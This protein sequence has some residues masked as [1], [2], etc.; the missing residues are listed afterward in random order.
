MARVLSVGITTLDIINQVAAYPSED[1][2]VRALSQVQRRG[3]NAANLA[4]VLSQLGHTVD[5]AGVLINEPD[6]ALILTEFDQ[7]QIGYAH[8]PRLQTGKMP[9]SYITVSSLNGSRTIVHVRDCPELTFDQFAAIDLSGYD[10]IHF[11][12]RHVPE[13]KR[14]LAYVA[15][16]HPHLPRSVELE[17]PREGIMSL[18]EQASLVMCS[19]PFAQAMG[20]NEPE[21][22]LQTLTLDNVTCSW[23]EAGVWGKSAQQIYNVSAVPLNKVVDTLGAGDSLNAGLI[24]GFLQ[25]NTLRDSLIFAN[26]LA[27]LKCQQHGFSG[28][29][30]ILDSHHD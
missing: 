24:H 13:T 30:R 21:S 2:E 8:C 9:T 11:E 29:G 3:G 7:Y 23:G 5:F 15:Q 10:W 4:V 12:G 19:K 18:T 6:L 26:Q 14:M 17:K 20:H 22:F 25:N 28:L 1:D 16:H 27:A